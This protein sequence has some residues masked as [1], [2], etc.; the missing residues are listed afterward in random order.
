MEE[1]VK[2]DDYFAEGHAN[3]GALLVLQG[4]PKRALK[5]LDRATELDAQLADPYRFRGNIFFRQSE[6]QRSIESFTRYLELVP[7]AADAP[8]VSSLID[9]LRAIEEEKDSEN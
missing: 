7:D 2:V 6:S 4:D 3:L 9:L 8:Q 1:S 5:E